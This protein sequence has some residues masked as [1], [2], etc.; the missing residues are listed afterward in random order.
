MCDVNLKEDGWDPM[1][2]AMRSRNGVAF[3][4]LSANNTNVWTVVVRYSSPSTQISTPALPEA[5]MDNG[6]PND[7]T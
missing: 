7:D 5:S 6:L 4:H 1:A 3:W 2:E